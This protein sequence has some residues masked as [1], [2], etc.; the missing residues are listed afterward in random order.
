MTYRPGGQPELWSWIAYLVLP[1]AY[2][3]HSLAVQYVSDDGY[4]AFQYVRNLLRG[5]GLVYNPGERVEG[6][7]NFLWLMVLAGAKSLL[8]RVELLRIAQGLGIFFG[9]ATIVL[10]LRFSQHM[11]GRLGPFGALGAAFLVVHSGLAA[12]ATAGLETTM[13]AFLLLAGAISY[14]TVLQTGRN[15]WLPP[16]IFSLAALTRPEGVVAFAV[17]SG[18]AFFTLRRRTGRLVN[19]E[20]VMWMAVFAAIYVPYYVWRFNYYGYPLPNTAYA[21]VG[22]GIFQHL[23]GMAYLWRYLMTYGGFVFLPAA[24]LLLQKRREAWRDYFALLV[25]GQAVFIVYVGGDGLAFYR[26]AVYMAPVAYL[27]VQE[28]FVDLFQR[29][30]PR[31]AAGATRSVVLSVLVIAMAFTMQQSVGAL[32]LPGWYRWYEPQSELSFPGQGSDHTYM[33]FDNY[34]VERLA[35]AAAWLEANTPRHAVVASTPAGSI[36]YHMDRT[37]IDMLG[38]N[39]AHIAHHKGAVGG[40]MGRG[41]AGH[42]KGDGKYVLSRAPDYILMGNVAVLSFPIDQATMANKVVLKSEHEIWADPEFHQ[43]YELICVRLSEDGVLRYFT[44]YQRKGT[45][46][47]PHTERPSQA[48]CARSR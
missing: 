6:Y 5:E 40:V 38:L 4:I 43:K 45:S 19:R 16:V 17:T 21:K 46:L 23:R 13:I 12:W 47:L 1:A 24:L 37:V 34:F 14:V 36:A 31:F 48:S 26:F 27:L 32:V 2:V 10:A 44:F 22:E 15:L 9:A 3:A 42:E 30:T 33:W 20:I 35:R 28:G 7:N 25:A 8:P 29:M 11:R 41:R 39:D 18:H